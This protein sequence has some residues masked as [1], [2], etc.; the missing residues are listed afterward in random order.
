MFDSLINSSSLTKSMFLLGI[1]LA[2]VFSVL[3][4]FYILIKLLL[5][6]FPEKGNN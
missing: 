6:L 3:I 2:G 5:K 4:L 1:G